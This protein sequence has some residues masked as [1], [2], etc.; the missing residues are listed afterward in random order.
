MNTKT[1]SKFFEEDLKA[2]QVNTTWSWGAENYFAVYLKLWLDEFNGSSYVLYTPT[3][4]DER[5]GQQERLRHVKAML[6]GKQGYA[7]VISKNSINNQGQKSIDTYDEHLYEI[8]NITINSKGQFIGIVNIEH[9]IR[10]EET[11][12]ELDFETAISLCKENHLSEKTLEKAVKKLKWNI[13]SFSEEHNKLIFSDRD[14]KK[15]SSLDI[16]TSEWKIIKS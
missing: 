15:N 12:K 3:D 9:P 10:I 8:K 6:Q 7:V 16:K 13:V 11:Q 4:S 2:K 14:N 5:N 1:I